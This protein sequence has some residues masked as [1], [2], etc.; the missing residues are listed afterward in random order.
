VLGNHDGEGRRFA[1]GAGSLAV[2]ANDMRTRHFPNPVPDAFYTGNASRD[3]D[4]G[5]LENYYT[6]RWGDARLIVLDPFWP[7]NRRGGDDGWAWTLGEEQY[8][9][10]ERTLAQ[11]D[12]RFTFVFIHHLVG[13]DQQARGGVEASTR[14]EWGGAN[15]DGSPGFASRRPGWGLPIHDL[16]VKHRVSAVFHG[17]DHLYAHEQRDGLTYQEVPQP[18]DARG[19]SD[20]AAGG[21]GYRSGTV[22]GGTGYLRV[23]VAHEAAAV[24][25]VDVGSKASP[26]RVADRYVIRPA[27]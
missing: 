10:L 6:W 12:A 9:W 15:A 27:R 16:L 26:P 25:F 5:L 1:G 13:G 8:R 23:K 14:F 20:R 4:A 18:G 2:W 22:L 3:P 19:G 24:E 17:H 7:S 11:N 21:Y